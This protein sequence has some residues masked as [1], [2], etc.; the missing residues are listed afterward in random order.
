M[1]RLTVIL[2]LGASL[3]LMAQ[4]G[5]KWVVGQAVFADFNSSTHFKSS[6]GGGVGAGTWLND[7]FGLDV[8]ALYLPLKEKVTGT[9][10]SEASGLASLLINLRPGAD[11]WNPYVSL[12]PG[13]SSVGGGLSGTG[14]KETCFNYHAGL[15]VLGH[16]Q[17]NLALQA[18]VQALRVY[19]GNG[20]INRTELL[21]TLGVGYT[22]GGSKTLT[23]APEPAPAPAPEPAPA[24]APAPEPAPA[25]APAPEPAPA[26]APEP[27]VVKPAPAP[28]PVKIILDEATLHFK[29]GKAQLGPKAVEAIKRVAASLQVYKGEYTLKV[30]GHTSST[31]SKAVNKALSKHRA[32]AVAKVLID[33]GV[34]ASAV[35]VEGCGPDKP[36]ADNATAAGQAKNRRVEIDVN[37][38]GAKAEIREHEVTE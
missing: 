27:V 8:R 21:A 5:Q 24:P 35:S 29:N 37:L 12:G 33:N 10:S 22:W 36:I 20:G 25:P 7:R 28:E 6:F 11:N 19:V 15:G 26:P 23:V 30:S 38:L 17:Q 3:S 18:D 31:G 2:A 14:E 13:L 32:E 1:R 16:V 9:K 34:K 4:E